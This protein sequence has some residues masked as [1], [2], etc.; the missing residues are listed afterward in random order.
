MLHDDLIFERFL[1]I[2]SN[3][4]KEMKQLRREMPKKGDI[5]LGEPSLM[6]D[7][8]HIAHKCAFFMPKSSRKIS[9]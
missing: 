9:K 5:E 4:L 2:Q 7:S 1:Y 3:G 6:D 8:T